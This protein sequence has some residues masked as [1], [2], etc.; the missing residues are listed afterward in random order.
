MHIVRLF[1]VRLLIA[2]SSEPAPDELRGS[3]VPVAT[4]KVHLFENNVELLDLLRRLAEEERVEL[5]GKTGP[6]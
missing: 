1:I 6:N 5:E 3:V 4:Q 2:S